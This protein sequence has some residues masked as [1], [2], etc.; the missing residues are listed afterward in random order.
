V[1]APRRRGRAR[2]QRSSFPL[3]IECV[4]QWSSPG[5]RCS[6]ACVWLREDRKVVVLVRFDE[7]LQSVEQFIKSCIRTP[8]RRVLIYLRI[9]SRGE[10]CIEGERPGSPEAS[11]A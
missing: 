5:P 4:H 1:V 11:V 7:A 8:T 10:L 6:L 9:V 3:R 2:S